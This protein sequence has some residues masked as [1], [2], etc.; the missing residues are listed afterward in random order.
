MFMADPD[1]PE[2][3]TR[4]NSLRLSGFDYSAKRYYFVTLVTFQ[5]RRV[6]TDAKLANATLTCLSQLRQT[7]AFRV[8]SYCLMP[9]HFHALLGLGDSGKTLAE[10][11][12]AFKSLSTRAYWRWYEGR[13]WQRQ[14][15]DHIIRNETDLAETLQYIELNPA[16]EGLFDWPYVGHMDM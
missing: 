3:Y 6:F 10:I 16:R 4:R 8:Y 5:R 1:A 9:D 7:M 12:G 13:L 14:F 2:P 11:C 15:F